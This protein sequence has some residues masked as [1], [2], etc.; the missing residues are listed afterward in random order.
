MADACQDV[1]KQQQPQDGARQKL[2]KVV[3]RRKA[4]LTVMTW[5][6]VEATWFRDELMRAFTSTR[7]FFDS[8]CVKP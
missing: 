8:S 3:K 1:N 4:F 6:C 7:T 5:L 2:Q